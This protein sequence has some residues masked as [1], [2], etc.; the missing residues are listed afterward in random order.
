MLSR[1]FVPTRVRDKIC[2]I[3]NKNKTCTLCNIS[4]PQLKGRHSD[5]VLLAILVNVRERSKVKTFGPV[6]GGPTGNPESMRR[7]FENNQKRWGNFMAK[8]GNKNTPRRETPKK[9]HAQKKR[10]FGWPFGASPQRALGSLPRGCI[11]S[12]W[13]YWY[14]RGTLMAAT[15][16]PLLG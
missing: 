8:N 2:L 16:W 3:H 14:R 1:V 4:R 13:S 9:I 5:N 15:C 11:F 10:P 7:T 6:R 12:H